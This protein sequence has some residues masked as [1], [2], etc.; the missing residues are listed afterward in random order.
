MKIDTGLH[1]EL[2]EVG[3]AARRAEAAGYDGLFGAEM[4]HD[5][6]L[7][8]AL[9]SQ[10]T[11]RVELGTGIAV[12]FARN[13]MTIAMIGHDLQRL[14]NG[15]FLLGL[16][17]Q[18]K[19]HITKRF[20]MP[21]SNP[22]PR[23]REFILA[24]RAIWNTWDTGERLAFRGEFYKYTLMTP[25]F[26][27][28]P[29][30]F[31]PPPVLLAAVGPLMT[32]VAAEVADGLVAHAFTTPEYFREITLAAVDRGLASSG[33]PRSAFQIS[34]PLFVVTGRDEAQL[35]A[36]A[37]PTRAQLAF[38]GSTPAYRAVLEHHGWG[39]L[40]D[41]LNVLSKR[42]EWEKMGD[43]ITDEVLRAFAIVGE[44]DAI[45]PEV[46][47]RFGGLLDRVQCFAADR[48]DHATWAPVLDALRA[49]SGPTAAP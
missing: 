26:D 21:W 13:P 17:S 47:R 30:R 34:M 7:P 6:F 29:N 38:Y 37:K 41:E 49:V 14:S 1:G 23:M 39:E 40:G 10:T 5:P 2:E 48:D 43:A 18:I 16:G 3:D 36:N 45:A 19:P 20:S 33:R 27:P 44:P 35:R 32:T 12:A 25:M 46:E 22:A 31:G 42:G 15:R 9:A 8:I 24:M 4:A 11:S 28:G